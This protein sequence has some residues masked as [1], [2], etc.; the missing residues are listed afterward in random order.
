LA[1][2]IVDRRR[3]LEQATERERESMSPSRIIVRCALS[4]ATLPGIA[5]SAGS[6]LDR[7]MNRIWWSTLD[8]LPSTAGTCPCT[9]RML[10]CSLVTRWPYQSSAAQIGVY[11]DRD[12]GSRMWSRPRICN[13][14]HPTVLVLLAATNI[15]GPQGP[16][17]NQER[18]IEMV[19]G[20]RNCYSPPQITLGQAALTAALGSSLRESVAILPQISPRLF[21]R[22][23]LRF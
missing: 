18:T 4:A 17:I 20:N 22:C 3:R 2:V 7:L 13:P 16:R 11:A 19:P 23:R 10:K 5:S 1:T 9:K 8:R 21:A 6:N 15:V 12:Q 14:K